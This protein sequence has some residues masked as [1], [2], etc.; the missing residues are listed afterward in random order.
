MVKIHLTNAIRIKSLKKPKAS[1]LNFQK[2]SV[3]CPLMGGI[4]SGTSAR[5]GFR[6]QSIIVYRTHLLFNAIVY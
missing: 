4:V 5:G 2:V 3:V 1:L 6:G